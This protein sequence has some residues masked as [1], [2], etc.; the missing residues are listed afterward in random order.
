M[1]L[2]D[3][4]TDLKSLKYGKDRPG[5]GDSG[6]PYQKV[7]INTVDSGFNRFR[8]TKFDD[9]L[10]RG[11][12][13]GAAN[14]SIVDTFRIGKFL[15]DFPK[16]PL[17]IVK[18]VGLQLSNPQLET[19]KLKTD[20]PTKGGGLLRNVG[21]LVLNTANKL[22]N[23]VG[24]TRIYNLGINT[25]A[26]VPVNAFGFHFNRHGLLP[27]QDDQTKYLAVA[28]NN[29]NEENNR[30]TG[31]RNRFGLGAN[32]DLN[33]GNIKLRKKEQKTLGAIA[34]TF[35]GGIPFANS[36]YNDIQNSRIA[37]YIGGPSSI[38]GIGRTLIQRV[39]ERTN[40]NLKIDY[41]KNR[42]F[43][44]QHIPEVKISSSFDFGISLFT[45]S[46]LIDSSFNLIKDTNLNINSSFLYYNYKNNYSSSLSLATTNQK[47]SYINA[48]NNIRNFVQASLQSGS[49]F[50]KEYFNDG[51][52]LYS[53]PKNDPKTLDNYNVENNRPGLE[54]KLQDFPKA[55]SSSLGPNLPDLIKELGLKDFKTIKF[56]LFPTE[57]RQISGFGEGVGTDRQLEGVNVKSATKPPK[58]QVGNPIPSLSDNTKLIRRSTITSYHESKNAFKDISKG[59]TDNLT[60][61]D[62]TENLDNRITANATQISRID[63]RLQP[64]IDG[65]SDAE[66]SSIRDITAIK[67]NS[68]IPSQRKYSELIDAIN[69]IPSSSNNSSLFGLVNIDNLQQQNKVNNLLSSD[70]LQTIRQV[71]STGFNT[72]PQGEI[73]YYNGIQTNGNLEKVVIKTGGS[74]NKI[75]REVR[76]GSGRQ[77]EINL[78]PI[79][80]KAGTWGDDV[81]GTHNIRDLVRFRIQAV[82]GA[83]PS[84]G[85]WMVFRA[86]LTD[87]SDNSDATWNEVKYAGR[88]D[89]FYIYD[90]FTR[91]ISV[92]FKV[93]A[94]SVD[95]MQFIYQKLNFLMGN[96]MPDYTGEGLMRGPI[97]RLS[98]GNWIDGQLGI[99]NNVSFKVPQDSPWEIAIDEPEGG[100]KL[101]ILPHVV[102][103]TLSFT[104][105]GSE[106]KGTNLISAKSL[107][108]SHLA[109]NN[110]GDVKNQYIQ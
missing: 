54:I 89:K 82:D 23:A 102:E 77:D 92:S 94:L 42:N 105:I 58:I 34:A 97:T 66:K 61:L 25:L 107:T 84:T 1:P 4:K 44:S 2:L 65:N 33:K 40:D 7:D 69:K 98:I 104:P 70:G 10:V 36:V 62:K 59:T 50:V 47:N 8:M 28:Q 57:E 14:A 43:N 93:A 71:S 35:A 18:Q 79:F 21:N 41:A 95:E 29:N 63:S 15:K 72:N 52:S 30:L 24:P 81:V 11:G 26:Q 46:N 109:Q 5:G 68:S 51:F 16:G 9:G 86:Y 64:F 53:N 91:K 48:S 19:K 100:K 110:T 103:V 17:F 27:V 45:T 60:R 6:Q 39:P 32:Y 85:K 22:V 13:V 3:L 106:T 55:T 73:T 49:I 87:L 108:T 12:V 90:G 20:N 99:I 78:T 83:N 76:I 80:D 37:D 67:Y 56:P 74:W 88:G 101:L 75:S 96:T 31:L 38:Y